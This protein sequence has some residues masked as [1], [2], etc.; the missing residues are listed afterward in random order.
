MVNSK[1][2]VECALNVLYSLDQNGFGDG[3]EGQENLP[4]MKALLAIEK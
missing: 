2:Y 1:D 3:N 4:W